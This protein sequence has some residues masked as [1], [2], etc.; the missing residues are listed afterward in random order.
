MKSLLFIF[1]ILIAC[2]AF[3]Q[4]NSSPIIH[5]ADGYTIIPDASIQPDKNHEYKA[6]YNATI[7]STDARQILPA[8]NMAGSELNAL[9]VCKIPIDHAKFVIV[10]HGDAI[11]GILDND[12]Y[13]K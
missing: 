7:M 12:H 1:S 5:E 2:P 11:F 9:G 13:K 8:L 10:F 3:A 4:T 6:I